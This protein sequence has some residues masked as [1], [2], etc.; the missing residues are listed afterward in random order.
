MKQ[1]EPPH[2]IFLVIG[3]ISC[4][5]GVLL[6]INF[7]FWLAAAPMTLSTSQFWTLYLLGL[8]FTFAFGFIARIAGSKIAGDL[9][10][11]SGFMGLIWY[12]A[13]TFDMFPN[14]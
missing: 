7:F 2:K 3:I 14:L 12:L 1:N 13:V 6:V 9:G 4:V 8:F 10:I 11:V 5:I